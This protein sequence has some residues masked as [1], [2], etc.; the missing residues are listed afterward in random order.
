V[1]GPY[2]LSSLNE[3]RLAKRNCPEKH[4]MLNRTVPFREMHLECAVLRG[5]LGV[6]FY[7]LLQVFDCY[8]QGTADLHGWESFCLDETIDFGP[9]YAE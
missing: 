5:S 3:L 9:A 1:Q 2:I 4:G 8:P 7:P 6:L